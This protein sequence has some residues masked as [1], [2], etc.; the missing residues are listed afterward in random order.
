MNSV[1]LEDAKAIRKMPLTSGEQQWLEKLAKAG[2]AKGLRSAA[3][4]SL[5]TLE[6]RG[7]VERNPGT[8][9][10]NTQWRIT[11]AGASRL[12]I[13]L[14]TGGPL[15][16]L[17]GL[18]DN[19][20]LQLEV[21]RDYGGWSVGPVS[22]LLKGLASIG[23]VEN[24]KRG[25]KVGESRITKLGVEALRASLKAKGKSMIKR[26]KE[27]ERIAD[28]KGWVVL[29]VLLPEEMLVAKRDFKAAVDMVAERANC[30]R[31]TAIQVVD[32]FLEQQG[33]TLT[34]NSVHILRISEIKREA[35]AARKEIKRKHA[36]EKV[37]FTQEPHLSVASNG[38][39]TLHLN[40]K[41]H[42]DSG[43]QLIARVHSVAIA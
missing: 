16:S 14:D 9:G 4:R 36:G 32:D 23:L 15:A 1:K 26:G 3:Y 27:M 34:N 5:I 38:R 35:Q 8:S 22:D 13:N 19:A 17:P 11:I 10:Y 18:S 37:E 39:V 33:L 20:V 2:W 29:P 24:K 31:E 30:V 43:R 41:L 40:Y 21:L 42:A 6:K 28:K 7:F 12:G 25:G